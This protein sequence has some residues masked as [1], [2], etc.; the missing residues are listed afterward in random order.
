MPTDET[1]SSLG[2]S[3]SGGVVGNEASGSEDGDEL[4]IGGTEGPSHSEKVLSDGVPSDPDSD[5]SGEEGSGDSSGGDWCDA[6]PTADS[7]CDSAEG[8][9]VIVGNSSSG[10]YNS[11][12][13]RQASS[14]WGEERYNISV[15]TDD[16]TEGEGALLG[17]DNIMDSRYCWEGGDIT[18]DSPD[19]EVSGMGDD[20]PTNMSFT[21]NKGGAAK[22]GR[23]GGG[24]GCGS[25]I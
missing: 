22:I 20:P 7:T 3:E 16:Q 25:S 6:E 10:G 18:L 21:R 12:P 8:D 15:I 5:N 19:S 13:I 17:G 11:R 4:G 24:A 9:M 14:E 23:G 1:L 2:S